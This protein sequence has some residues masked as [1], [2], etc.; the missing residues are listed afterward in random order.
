M[1]PDLAQAADDGA[2][3]AGLT[4]V[5][6]PAMGDRR[7]P[8][9]LVRASLRAGGNWPCTVM[10][11][12]SRPGRCRLARRWLVNAG[13]VLADVVGL[14]HLDQGSVVAMSMHL[15]IDFRCHSP[16]MCARARR[17]PVLGEWSA[18]RMKGC[19]PIGP[20]GRRGVV[21][22]GGRAQGGEKK[23]GWSSVR[24]GPLPE[25]LRAQVMGWGGVPQKHEKLQTQRCT[26]RTAA[27][28]PSARLCQA[29]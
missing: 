5:C 6:S 23:S 12:G 13:Q 8:V 16:V 29:A 3:R 14:Q 15:C 4:G 19:K 7:A 24:T 1:T 27:R 28:P 26:I 21:G 11:V 25:F 20:V 2:G 18:E 22:G 17:T 9:G 10:N